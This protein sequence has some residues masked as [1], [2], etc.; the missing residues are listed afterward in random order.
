[1]YLKFEFG[2]SR[3]IE[4]VLSHSVVDDYL[5]KTADNGILATLHDPRHI[6]AD[7]SVLAVDLVIQC[8]HRWHKRELIRQLDHYLCVL[9]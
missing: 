2:G 4:I 5:F 1:V 9:T 8:T 6:R 7:T 3:V